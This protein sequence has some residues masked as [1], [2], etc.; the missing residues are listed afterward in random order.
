MTMQSS[1]EITFAQIQTEHSGS[2]PI[3]LNEYYRGGSLT[4]F[5]PQNT[6]IPESGTIADDDFYSSR[7]FGATNG[8][9]YTAATTGGKVPTVGY[10]ATNSLGSITQSSATQLSTKLT[11]I[12]WYTF[13]TDFVYLKANSPSAATQNFMNGKKMQGRTSSFNGTVNHYVDFLT[14]NFNVNAAGN[15]NAGPYDGETEW[16]YYSSISNSSPNR[17][18]TVSAGT[19]YYAEIVNR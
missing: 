16:S 6:N 19:T 12:G 10:W 3:G 17:S 15:I 7:G 11:L 13:T 4:A 14:G 8:F 9:I 18:G 5:N 1:G 2:N